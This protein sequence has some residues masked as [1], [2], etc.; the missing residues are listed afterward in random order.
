MNFLG[1][2][3]HFEDKRLELKK[4]VTEFTQSC[5]VRA[6]TRE[7]LPGDPLSWTL[8]PGRFLTSPQWF[9]TSPEIT[10]PL[11]NKESLCHWKTVVEETRKCAWLC[12]SFVVI[13]PSCVTGP[14]Q[15][16]GSAAPAMFISGVVTPACCLHHLRI[17]SGKREVERP[18]RILPSLK[19]LPTYLQPMA[20]GS[21]PDR[22]AGLHAHTRSSS[23]R[24][25]HCRWVLI[26]SAL[27]ISELKCLKQSPNDISGLFSFLL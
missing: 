24:G 27:H 25:Q 13:G 10:D 5:S 14:C 23:C 8:S 15:T 11:S 6:T 9:W 17:K 16:Q 3:F 12:A 1:H 20:K 2:C 22:T 7:P 18:L 21:N 4:D 19:N 26:L